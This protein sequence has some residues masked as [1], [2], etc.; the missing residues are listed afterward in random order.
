M[1]RP[2]G[3]A[4]PGLGGTVNTI[5][6]SPNWAGY[7]VASARSGA[8]RS[9]SASW[10]QPA[11]HCKGVAGHRYAAFW[12]GLDGFN[13]GDM[14]VEQT[15]ADSDCTGTKPTYY[16]WY[17]MFPAFPVFFRT[18]IRA[19]DHMSASVTFSGTKTYTLVLRDSTRHWKKTIVKNS[20]TAPRTS[21]EVIAEAPTSALTGNVL[22]LANFGSMRWTG[23][24]VNGTLL[25]KIGRRIR[26]IM[27]DSP[28]RIKCQTSVIGSADAF[29]N[30]YVRAT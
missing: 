2:S 18:P 3:V 8:F 5:V 29:I 1:I 28:S 13:Q 23:S 24:K 22:P 25:R 27:A 11:A 14:N 7:A 6:G 16:G 17:E 19:G 10:V 30:R 26:I 21:A 9:V 15:G 4:M 12:V 20:T